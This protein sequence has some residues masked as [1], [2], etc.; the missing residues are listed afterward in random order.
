MLT[1]IFVEK[2]PK[3]A[4]DLLLINLAWYVSFL[5][6]NSAFGLFVLWDRH[7]KR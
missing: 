6:E 5:T 1:F 2:R 4:S 7:K 3:L